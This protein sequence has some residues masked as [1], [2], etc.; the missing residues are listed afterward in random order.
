[1]IVSDKWIVM[2]PTKVI[3]KYLQEYNRQFSL[4]FIFNY[5]D[6][7]NIAL[8]ISDVFHSFCILIQCFISLLS[9]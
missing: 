2:A 3:E 9:T 1:M 4:L 5:Y 8:I 6:K 7:L